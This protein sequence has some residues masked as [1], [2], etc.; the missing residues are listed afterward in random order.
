MGILD[1][2][3]RI[4][5]KGRVLIPKNIREAL[6]LREKQLLRVKIVDGKLMLEP[7]GNIADK[8]YGILKVKKW[9]HDLDEFLIEAVQKSWREGM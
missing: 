5:K 1:V 7:L 3:V 2:V 9:P 8:Y 6:G 4:D